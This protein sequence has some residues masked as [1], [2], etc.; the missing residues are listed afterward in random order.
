M[1]ARASVP[2]SAPVAFHRERLKD[3]AVVMGKATLVVSW[4]FPTPCVASSHQLYAGIPRDEI[5]GVRMAR[6]ESFSARLILLIMSATRS[7]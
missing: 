1:R 5:A 7:D 2:I 3:I 6:A 4:L